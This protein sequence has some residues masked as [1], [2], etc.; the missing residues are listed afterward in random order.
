MNDTRIA[1]Y[2]FFLTIVSAYLFSDTDKYLI[3]WGVY[4]LFTVVAAFSVLS[5]GGR[6]RVYRETWLFILFVFYS[7][8]SLFWAK[9]DKNQSL[10]FLLMMIIFVVLACSLF[11]TKK[12]VEFLIKANIWSGV[13]LSIYTPFIYGIRSYIKDL[14]DGMRMGSEVGG[15]N[16]VGICIAISLVMALGY[17]L[18]KREKWCVIAMAPMIFTCFSTGSRTALLTLIAGV[19]ITFFIYFNITSPHKS[20]S[21]IKGVFFSVT[22][23]VAG[24]YL[25]K[26]I[27]A[28]NRLFVRFDGLVQVLLGKIDSTEGVGTNRIRN[29][30]IKT[31]MNAFWESPFLG[32]GFN[33]GRY[34]M[35]GYRGNATYSLHNNYVDVL[36]GGGIVGFII[37]YSLY[38]SLFV[39]L[40]KKSKKQNLIAGIALG[41]ML[42]NLIGHMSGVFY[43][44]KFYYPWLIVWIVAAN[45]SDVSV[46]RDGVNVEQQNDYSDR[47]RRNAFR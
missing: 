34:L 47:F 27:P 10:S 40:L 39:R 41:T 22:F 37:F 25:L 36:C 23:L 42:L 28:F 6:I 11:T 46:D 5:Q 20:I 16:T 8:V 31:G 26:Y 3:T 35:S 19:P 17:Y 7:A 30:L 33:N 18:F 4:I 14:I 24:Y 38:V 12:D 45:I 44:L 43:L 1:K 15:A 21:V 32:I 9:Y 29:V 13:I 2:L